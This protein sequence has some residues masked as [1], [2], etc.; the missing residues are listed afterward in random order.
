MSHVELS[1]ALKSLNRFAEEVKE[2]TEL[3]QVSPL[4]ELRTNSNE[5]IRN[6]AGMLRDSPKES[7]VVKRN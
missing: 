5:K 7:Q 6:N 1:S 4:Y 3:D 2:V